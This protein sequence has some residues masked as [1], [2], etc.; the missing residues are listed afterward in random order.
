MIKRK[1]MLK[2]RTG[3]FIRD[4]LWKKYHNGQTKS[5][6]FIYIRRMTQLKIQDRELDLLVFRE[7]CHAN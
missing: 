6:L 5:G 2:Y 7:I 1:P 3:L 4:I